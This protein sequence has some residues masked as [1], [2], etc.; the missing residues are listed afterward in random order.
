MTD[1]LPPAW[2]GRVNSLGFAKPP[3]ET[4]V[5]AAMSGGVDSSVVAAMLKAQGYDVIGI[6]LQLYDHGAA[7]EKKGACCAGQ[8]IHDARNVSDQIGIPHYVLDY[9]TKFR[10][11]VMEDFADTYLAGSTPIPC[12]RCNQTVKFSDLLKTARDLGADCLATGHYIRRTDGDDGPELHRAAD[13][14]RDQSYF[15]FATTAEQLDYLRFPLGDLPKTQV[16]ELADQFNLPVASKPDSQDICFV[17]EGSYATVVEK[18]RPGAG[19]GGDIEHLDGRV[20]GQH[21][22][23]IHYTIG[24]R[25]GL[26]VATGDPLYVVKIDAPNRRVI[27][28]PREA[29]MTSG[30]LLEELN[31]LG[32]GSLQAAAD[33]GVPVLVRVR[34]T[35][36]PVPARLG[37][38]D[39]VPVIWFDDPEEG[40]ARGQAAVLYDAE[41]STRIL[42][43]GFILKPI[44]ADE[45][46]VA[47]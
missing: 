46:V 18:L 2:D 1:E 30:L 11:Q 20:L 34:S 26:G 39:G 9:E 42:G 6:T 15:L 27:V 44:P 3:A 32:E 28:G 38:S 24:Q 25:R 40:V 43:G 13:A 37:W 45:R 36:P 47:A 21:N 12:I 41:G 10:E 19:R 33:A 4:R 16:R 29:L 17:P 7:I 23:V 5:V 14:S 35:R 22:G 31:W 8:D